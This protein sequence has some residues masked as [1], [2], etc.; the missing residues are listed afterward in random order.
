M[1]VWAV[2]PC[3]ESLPAQCE[4][5]SSQ[6]RTN[7][8][9]LFRWNRGSNR[10]MYRS[11]VQFSLRAAAER[12]DQDTIIIIVVITQV[13]TV[14]AVIQ[15]T[16][17]HQPL[18]NVF[19]SKRWPYSIGT[20]RP[21]T[22]MMITTKKRSSELPLMTRREHKEAA[23]TSPIVGRVETVKLCKVAVKKNCNI[24]RIILVSGTGEGEI[25]CEY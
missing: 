10:I 14:A 17:P 19:K 23:R 22:V 11:L 8:P 4:V 16:E 18:R 15:S 7:C 9:W 1:L 3:W 12:Q 24:D 21:M 5:D 2:V 20:A 25:K 6:A 13:G